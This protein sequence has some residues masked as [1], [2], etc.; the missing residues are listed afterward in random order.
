MIAP[1]RLRKKKPTSTTNMCAGFTLFQNKFKTDIILLYIY[2]NYDVVVTLKV[3]IKYVC[4][5]SIS[6]TKNKLL[7]SEISIDF[8]SFR[9]L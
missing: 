6:F 3:E 9:A 5:Q 8:E 4:R 1:V 2:F 7:F